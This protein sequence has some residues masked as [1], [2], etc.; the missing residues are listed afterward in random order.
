MAKGVFEG[1]KVADFAW[2]A[3]GPQ[4]GREL[5]EHGATVV[6]VESHRAPDILR[7]S[8]PFKDGIVGIDR[9]A[10]GMECHTNKYGMSLDL[11]KPK[12]REIGLKMALWADIVS[13]GM[14]PGTMK[15]WGLDYETLSKHKPDLIM[16]STCQQGQYGPYAPHGTYGWAGAAMSGSFHLCGWPD[17]DPSLVY[18]AYN[19]FISPWYLI[20]TVIAALEHRRRTGQGMYLDQSQIEAGSTFLGPAILDYTVNGQTANRAGNR[21]PYLAPHGAFPCRGKDR[22]C[23]IAVSNDE[24]WLAFCR[25]I[26]EPEW[27]GDPRFATTL[28]RKEREDELEPLIAEWTKDYT[29]EQVMAMMQ[30]AGVP[31]GVVQDCLD[32]FTDPQLKHREHFRLLQH[33]VIGPHH[34]SA[35]AYKLSKTPAHIWKAGPCLGEDNEFVYKDILGYSDDEVTQF[36]LDGVITTENDVPDA[37]KPK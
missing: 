25:I 27:T 15:K 2:V 19:D 33:K 17:R 1:I 6:R 16:F 37:L 3:A 12:G 20:V 13:D 36:L 21:D 22:W 28:S 14:V 7:L 35:P 26:G 23:N 30:S 31:A 32:L 24:E 4:V 11:S 34:Y 8:P 18:G 5:A 10:F 9:S 29:A